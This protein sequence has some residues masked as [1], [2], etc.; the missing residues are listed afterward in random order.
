MFRIKICGV[1]NPEDARFAAISGADAVGVNFFAGSRRYVPPG[2]AATIVRAVCD[3]G[4]TPVAVFVN[5]RPEVIEAQAYHQT[6][7]FASALTFTRSEGLLPAPES[8][9]A[10][11]A[12]I[13]E[14][15]K[16]DA[17]GK[18]RTILFNLSGHGFFDLA[19]YDDYKAGRLSDYEHPE[20]SIREALERLP[21]VD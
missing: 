15:K 17:E 19:A 4:A 20:S 9:H 7:I 2:A 10:I 14:A 16:A 11:H 8:S 6:A 21:K 18:S 12:A 1:T 3:G 5:E 13:V